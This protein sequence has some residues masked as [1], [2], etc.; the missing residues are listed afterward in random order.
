MNENLLQYAWQCKLFSFKNLHTTDGS[1]VEVIDVGQLNHDAG[2]DFFN[3]KIKI[4]DTFWAGNVEIHRNASDWFKHHHETDDRYDSII[5]HVVEKSDTQ[6]FRKNGEKIPQM[7]LSVLQ[8]VKEKYERIK[9]GEGWIRCEKFWSTID[10][11]FLKFQISHLAYERVFRKAEII[12]DAYHTNQNDWASTFYQVLCRGFGMHTNTLPFELLAKSLPLH[13]LA[14]QK[15]NLSELEALLF[16]QAGLLPIVS[17]DQYELLLMQ[18]FKH[19]QA[20][21]SLNPIDGSLWKFSKMRPTN[22]PHIRLAQLA[23]LIHHSEHLFSKIIETEDLT[24][25]RNLLQCTP[26]AYW[27]THYRFGK[28][29]SKK[30]KPLTL[31]AINSLIINVVIP[32]KFAYLGFKGDELAQ[33]DTLQ[34]LEKIPPEKNS[35]IEGWEHLDLLSNDAFTSQALI[36]LKTQYCDLGKCLRCQIGHHLLQR[37][38]HPKEHPTDPKVDFQLSD[39]QSKPLSYS[40]PTEE[41]DGHKNPVHDPGE[42]LHE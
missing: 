11:I 31:S 39:N 7:E 38:P 41:E 32:I 16:G 36:E 35:I 19:L 30:S 40:T 21:F 5:L 15:N 17:E 34:L 23:S 20:K 29:S 6:I 28:E 4:D 1:C 14:K 9:E 26:S 3:A 24:T 25:I 18:N 13:D 37:P 33:D 42:V 2:P 10:P 27:D 8:D 22:F 12:Q